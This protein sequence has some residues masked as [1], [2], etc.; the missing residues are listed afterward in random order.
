MFSPEEVGAWIAVNVLDSEAWD[1]AKKPAVAVTQAERNLTRWYP[2]IVLT[3]P[4]V[5]MQAIWELQGIDP[6]LKYQKHN[7]KT[8]TDNGESV[9]YK[10][11][12]R[13]AVAPDVRDM[14]GP[15]ADELADEEAAADLQEQYGGYLL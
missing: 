10:D 6:A 14:L 13:P 8:V 12:A 4:V 15:T 1:K 5:G 2:S 3:V 7:V 9:S 11:G